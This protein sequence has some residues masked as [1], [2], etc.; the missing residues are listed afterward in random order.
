VTPLTLLALPLPL[1]LSSLRP[2]LTVPPLT[3]PPLTVPPLTVPPLT[4]P[5]LTVPNRRRSAP[6]PGFYE[7]PG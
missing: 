1:A 6:D 2:P 4:V 3:V 7:R 5:P